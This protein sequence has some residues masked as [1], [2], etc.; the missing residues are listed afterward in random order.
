[1]GVNAEAW[2]R[3]EFDLE[4]LRGLPSVLN[5]VC[6]GPEVWIWGPDDKRKTEEWYWDGLPSEESREG[7]YLSGAGL[8]IHV[9]DEALRVWSLA[10]WRGFLSDADLRSRV[11]AATGKIVRA[12]DATDVVWLPDWF[13]NHFPDDG[14]VTFDRVRRHLLSEWGPPQPSLELI[15]DEV[16]RAAEHSSPKVWF[17]ETVV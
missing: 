7:C 17:Q 8:T 10:R 14:I 9:R 16:L 15:N 1:M 5:R 13:L 3:K 12:L 4:W 2:I 6:P 11:R